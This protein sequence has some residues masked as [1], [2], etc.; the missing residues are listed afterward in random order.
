MDDLWYRVFDAAWDSFLRGS[1]GV[2]AIVVDHSG[3]IV[4][5]GR[6]MIN[7]P[8]EGSERLAGVAIAHAELNALSQVTSGIRGL[9]LMSSLQPC[10]MCSAALVAA[11]VSAVSFAAYDP[12]ID[13]PPVTYAGTQLPPVSHVACGRLSVLAELMPLSRSLQLRG[14]GSLAALRYR[15]RNPDLFEVAMNLSKS[16]MQALGLGI[17]LADAIDTL[18]S[19]FAGLMA[20]TAQVTR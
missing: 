17:T 11:R 1:Y 6:N 4:A 19:R 2:G 12:G 5:V 18:D 9:T 7:S 20:T 10:Y 13:R 14:E 3:E 8:P 15:E 16:T